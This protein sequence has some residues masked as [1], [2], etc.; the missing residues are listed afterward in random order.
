MKL[1]IAGV[2]ALTAACGSSSK[3]AVSNT[4]GA[5]AVAGDLDRD[6]KADQVALADGVVTAAGVSFT[7][8]ADYP[9]VGA[10]LVDLGTET[11]VAVDSE[12]VEDDLRWRILQFRDGALHDLGEVFVGGEP[13]AADL[14]GDGT[15]H[16]R[17][18]NCGQSTTLV[19]RVTDGK[20]DKSETTTGTYDVDQCTA[21]PYVFVDTAD[22][23]VFVGESL[24]NLV[25][26]ARQTEDAL[27]LPAVAADQRTLVVTLAEV[28]AET[29]F[30]DA[31][32]V[33][34]DGVIVAPRACDGAACTS[35]DRHDV[36]TIGERRRFVFDVP[37]GFSGQPVLRTRGYYEPFAPTPLAQ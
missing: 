24:R 31:I 12:V 36:F 8:P 17:H 3:P 16:A 10:R 15:I 25:G 18:G 4:G 33:D 21:C 26:R 37:V 35:D 13:E 2:L 28:K 23:T 34:F 1:A 27:A 5:T 14:P 20:L 22:G 29:T 19:Y 7:L 9:G 11:V 6:G 32:A 30:L